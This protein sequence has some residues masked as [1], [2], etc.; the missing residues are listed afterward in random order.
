MLFK[1]SN[2]NSNLALTLGYLNRALNNLAL[3]ISNRVVQSLYPDPK[4]TFQIIVVLKL[5]HILSFL[6]QIVREKDGAISV[7]ESSKLPVL[8]RQRKIIFM[9]FRI[10][11]ITMV[12]CFLVY[13]GALEH[14]FLIPRL[15]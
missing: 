9:K 2:L 8:K 1:L 4:Y 11:Q 15:S 13:L 14:H 3:R 12:F 5:V 7:S 10:M 6:W